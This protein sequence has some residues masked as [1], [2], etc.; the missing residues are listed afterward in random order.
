MRTQALRYASY[1]P[2]GEVLA[3]ESSELPEPARG[4]VLLEVLA[5]PINHADLGRIAGSYGSLAPLPAT[6]GLEGVAKVVDRAQDVTQLHE[7]QRVFVP[8]EIGSWQR[9]AIANAATLYPAPEEFTAA[10]AA[11][12]WVNPPTAWKLLKD[13][14]ELRPGDY[15]AQNAATSAVGKLVIQ[16]ASQLGIRTINLARDLKSA[17]Q[18]EALGA[19]IVLEDN[20]DAAN[21][22]LAATSGQ[23]AKLALNSVG[24]ASAYGLCKLLEDRASLVTFGGMDR[25]P[26]PFPTRYLIF[27]DLRLRGLWIGKW[28]QQAQ[29]S[30][31]LELQREV[32]GFM[33]NARISVDIAATYPLWQYKEALAQS[34]APGKPGKVLFAPTLGA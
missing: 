27:N 8:S 3:L 24:G 11:M 31:V 10:Q 34:Q 6:G 30:E 21:A 18:L 33:A 7:G 12:A 29:R 13:F 25:A 4:Q 28:Y 23:R 32:Y 15:I 16:F 22:A 2:P 5:A 9:F 20:R 17:A 14:A 19:T 26:S 1:G